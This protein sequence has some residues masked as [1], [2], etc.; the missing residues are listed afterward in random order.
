MESNDTDAPT[1]TTTTTVAATT[2]IAATTATTTPTTVPH[3]DDADNDSAGCL[4]RALC[5][6]LNTPAE[7]CHS[8]EST[9][10]ADYDSPVTPDDSELTVIGVTP[11]EERLCTVTGT[12]PVTF[13]NTGGSGMCNDGIDASTSLVQLDAAAAPMKVDSAATEC[14]GSSSSTGGSTGIR[15]PK[16]AMEESVYG[17]ESDDRMTEELADEMLSLLQITD[18]VHFSEF[19]A[20]CLDQNFYMREN[21]CRAAFRLFDRDSDGYIS[22]GEL[23]EALGWNDFQPLLDGAM[24]MTAPQYDRIREEER[25]AAA[26]GELDVIM[27]MADAD[28]DGKINFEDFLQL[29]TLDASSTR[30][31]DPVLDEGLGGGDDSDASSAFCST[32]AEAGTPHLV[33]VDSSDSILRRDASTASVLSLTNSDTGEGRSLSRIRSHAATMRMSEE[34]KNCF[35]M[36]MRREVLYKNNALGSSPVSGAP[37]STPV[38]GI[39]AGGD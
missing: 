5:G 27:S 11:K 20:A 10:S 9:V 35:S 2:T 12:V 30:Y 17:E 24:E 21:L 36:L 38:S 22:R 39:N 37:V 1:P 26:E 25:K 4:Y 3:T 29:L 7:Y 15:V 14:G 13:N 28:G 18:R 6:G 16:G 34:I 8:E 23:R 19:L 33:A 32:T 31:F